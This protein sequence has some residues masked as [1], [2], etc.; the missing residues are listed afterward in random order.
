MIS[1]KYETLSR[2]NRWL[3]HGLHSLDFPFLYR[4]RPAWDLV[5]VILSAGGIVL[6]VTTMTAAWRRLQRHAR[7]S[8]PAT[9]LSTLRETRSMQPSGINSRKE[10]S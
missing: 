2:V 5:V 10:A 6:S 1:L 3:Y 7:A 8:L 9:R 4:S